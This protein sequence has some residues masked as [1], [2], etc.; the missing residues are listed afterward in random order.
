M[1]EVAGVLLWPV[2]DVVATAGMWRIWWRLGIQDLRLRFRRSMLGV[3]WI[4]VQLVVMILAVGVVYGSLFG[5]DLR[6]F[7]PYLTV[8]LVVWGFVTASVVEG[9]LALVASEGYIKQIGLPVQVYIMR[10]FVSVSI[11]TAINLVA[12]V[13]VAGAY[14]VPVGW[15]VLWAFPGFA[16][17]GLVGL[18]LML[19]FAHVN[20]RFRDTTHLAT[21]GLQI[22]FF[23]TPV[24]WP[25]D[26]LRG[27]RLVWIVDMNPLYHL[28]EIIRQPLLSSRP[29]NLESY[30]VGL[31]VAV[32]LGVV[33]NAVVIFYSRRIVYLL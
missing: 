13:I 15:G 17:L 6:T 3:G 25:A 1:K 28:L 22:L 31:G 33:A 16:L 14:R 19:I 21:V 10:F 7:L 18:F 20:V 11:T 30:L 4:L 26:M 32:C 27:R 24:L 8:G 9:G 5:Q 12:Y 2:R 29:A 23:V